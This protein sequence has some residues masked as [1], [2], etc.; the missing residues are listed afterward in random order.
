MA[1]FSL[2]A[3]NVGSHALGEADRIVVMFSREKGLHRA[4][5]KGARKPGTKMAGKSE[6]LN[7]NRLLLSKGKSLDIITQCESVETFF[8]LRQDLERLSYAL[9][10]AELTQTF[11]Q[12]LSEDSERYFDRLSMAIGLMSEGIKDPAVQCLEFEL[13]LLDLIGLSPELSFC[14]SCRQPVTD[15]NLTAFNYEHGGLVCQ[16]CFQKKRLQNLSGSGGSQPESGFVRESDEGQNASVYLTPL[17]WKRLILARTA[18]QEGPDLTDEGTNEG[19]TRVV[20]DNV[21][22]SIVA[23][24]RLMQGY[25]EYKSGRRMKSLEVLSSLKFHKSSGDG[26]HDQPLRP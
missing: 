10:F 1:T 25:I 20:S 9:Y 16:D 23:A 3:V 11:G 5:A 17:V 19:L 21:M 8:G 7:I 22:R 26:L 4:V 2:T 12:D 13:A 14:V 24:R 15:H 18:A 6:P